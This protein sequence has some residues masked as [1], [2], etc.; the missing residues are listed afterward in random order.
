MESRTKVKSFRWEQY[1]KKYTTLSNDCIKIKFYASYS[2]M[3]SYAG[4]EDK[5]WQ[6]TNL[7]TIETN[8][9]VSVHRK[10]HSTEE[11]LIKSHLCWMSS[12]S[13]F[14]KL[15]HFNP[16]QLLHTG[17]KNFLVS[18]VSKSQVHFCLTPKLADS[19]RLC[20]IVMYFLRSLKTCD[21]FCQNFLFPT[22]WGAVPASATNN[23]YPLSCIDELIQIQAAKDN[24][25]RDR[26]GQRL[27]WRSSSLKS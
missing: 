12:I 2:S 27:L 18:P 26:E 25:M 5:R 14:L 1:M 21:A 6:L 20:K 9:I 8:R 17:H 11:Q 22:H 7:C 13:C 4:K 19:Y 23:S 10:L 3:E 16:F 15:L 24:K